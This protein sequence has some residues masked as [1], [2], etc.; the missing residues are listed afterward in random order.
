MTSPASTLDDDR[1]EETPTASLIEPLLPQ[2]ESP[3]DAVVLV[4]DD[5][6]ARDDDDDNDNVD[7]EHGKKN[8]HL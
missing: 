4:S 6:A 7:I 8:F 1:L 2:E 3:L 5:S